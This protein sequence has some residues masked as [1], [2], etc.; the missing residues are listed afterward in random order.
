[1]GDLIGLLFVAG[2]VGGAIWYFMQQ[3]KAVLPSTG[4]DLS[5]VNDPIIQ[6][7]AMRRTRKL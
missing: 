2:G 5:P 4:G 6:A 3:Q 7:Q 1:M